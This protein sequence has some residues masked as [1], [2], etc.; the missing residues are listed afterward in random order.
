MAKYTSFNYLQFKD[1]YSKSD[2]FSTGEK[3][4]MGILNITEDSFYDGGKYLQPKNIITQVKKM[5]DNGASIIDIGAQSTKPNA[6]SKGPHEENKI[7]LPTIKLLKN[8]FKNLFISVDTYWSEVAEKA[9]KS[10][11]NMINDVS[12]GNIDSNM[13]KLISKLQVPYVL[14]HMKGK[15]D[16]MQNNPN[17]K[18][19]VG[20]VYTF[21][22]KKI[23]DLENL[24]FN[25]IILDPGFGFGKNLNHNYS[26]L[27]NLHEFKKLN[28]PILVGVSRKSMIYKLLN[29]SPEKA[30]NGTSIINT[31]ALK[32]GADIL[33]VHDV[34][35]AVECVKITDF[36][37]NIN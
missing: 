36:I 16:N 1:N 9:I 11:G 26:L 28:Y 31:V 5:L 33:R 35:E 32:N 3:I 30:L 7:L 2:Y 24:G 18:N 27:N 14:M 6:I 34:K 29:I 20:E 21:F 15:P 4:I 8:K 13:F 25:K 22:E 12:A 23:S 10:G 19:V 17:Y 37:K